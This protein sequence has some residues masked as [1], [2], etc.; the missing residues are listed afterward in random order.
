MGLLDDFYNMQARQP[1]SPF[2]DNSTAPMPGTIDPMHVMIAS[3]LAPRQNTQQ[4]QIPWHELLSTITNKTQY[5]DPVG[6][7][8]KMS[9]LPS[10]MPGSQSPFNTG[11]F[12]SQ[13]TPEARLASQ[14]PSATTQWALRG[15]VQGVDAGTLRGLLN[16]PKQQNS[17]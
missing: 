5:S 7:A 4:N 3:L 16:P 6:Y 17:Y 15:G 13:L 8:N 2:A 12:G 10:Y 11:F 1:Q 14:G 9:Q